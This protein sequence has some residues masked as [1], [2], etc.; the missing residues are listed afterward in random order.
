MEKH[1]ILRHEDSYKPE[2][3][4]VP[5]ENCPGGSAG[6]RITN[7]SN[8]T[9]HQVSYHAMNN[10]CSTPIMISK[11]SPLCLQSASTSRVKKQFYF[12]RLVAI[13]L[14]SRYKCLVQEIIFS[15]L[16]VVLVKLQIL[17]DRVTYPRPRITFN[18]KQKI[19]VL[20]KTKRTLYESI[21]QFTR[22]DL[23]PIKLLTVAGPGCSL[24]S[25]LVSSGKSE[26]LL[27]PSTLCRGSGHHAVSILGVIYL[28][29]YWTHPTTVT[30]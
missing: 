16:V 12:A 14:A 27:V 26:C 24:L 21:W 10:Q 30:R 20:I 5:T 19:E 11:W 25:D 9:F 17:S 28:L 2:C 1:V 23:P 7:P 6:K 18:R 4:C 29:T 3:I 13:S 22:A 8:L 15:L